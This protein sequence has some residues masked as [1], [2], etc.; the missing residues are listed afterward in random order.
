MRALARFS[1]RAIPPPAQRGYSPGAAPDDVASYD[2]GLLA[3]DVWAITD[4]AE[5]F[6][7]DGGSQARDA[8]RL[9]YFFFFLSH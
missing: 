3:S 1:R 2:Y 8:Y 9:L 4:A 7:P 6:L 5:G